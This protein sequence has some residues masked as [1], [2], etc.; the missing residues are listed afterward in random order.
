MSIQ[1]FTVCNTAIVKHVGQFNKKKKKF[2]F[3]QKGELI[4]LTSK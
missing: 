4:G 2:S 3:E 1:Q